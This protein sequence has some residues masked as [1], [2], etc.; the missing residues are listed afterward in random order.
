[1]TQN[2]NNFFSFAVC[3]VSAKCWQW[4]WLWLTACWGCMLYQSG[5][6][7]VKVRGGAESLGNEPCRLLF[8]IA[9]TC[10]CR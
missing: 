8:E 10:K 7:G 6:I 1:M 9:A 4:K 5:A 2:K 3:H